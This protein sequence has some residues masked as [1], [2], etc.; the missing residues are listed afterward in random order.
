MEE[1]GR[2]AVLLYAGDFDASG[3]DIDRDFLARSDCWAKVLRVAL[4]REQVD[5]YD[6]PP[7]PGKAS[8]PRARGFVERHGELVQVELDALPP[9]VLRDLYRDALAGFWD[10]DA[11]RT[12]RAREDE[13]REAL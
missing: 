10:R 12:A 11:Y 8:D 2:P 1:S 7:Q 3:E 6:L 9:D 13:D 4:S 5:A